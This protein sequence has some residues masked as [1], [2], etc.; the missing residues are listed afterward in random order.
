MEFVL[1]VKAMPMP[2]PQKEETWPPLPTGPFW[3]RRIMTW[4]I[5]GAGVVCFV[6]SLFCVI[7]LFFFLK[8]LLH[9][10]YLLTDDSK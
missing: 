7:C 4:A 2:P 8:T 9:L 6:I 5:G 3:I 10:L 1:G